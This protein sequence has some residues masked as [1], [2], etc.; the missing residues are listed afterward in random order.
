MK[1]LTMRRL[2]AI[3]MACLL[4]AVD[5][6]AHQAGADGGVRCGRK[7]SGGGSCSIEIRVPG[8]AGKSGKKPTGGSATR[9]AADPTTTAPPCVGIL[10]IPSDNQPGIPDCI[11][12]SGGICARYS[13]I[14]GLPTPTADKQ[15]EPGAPEPE[16]LARVAIERM[17]L[18][19]PDIGLW[20]EPLEDIPHGHSYVGWNNWM[21][22][23]NPTPTTWG[24]ITK[25]VTQAGH[26]ITATAAVTHVT[27]NMGN[28]DTKHCTKGTPHPTSHTHD[29]NS[30]TCG[31]VYHQRGDVT[32]TATAHWTITW[33]G[34]G[35]HGTITMDLSSHAHASIVE[36]HV[37][38]I[39]TGKHHHPTDT[40]TPSPNPTGTPT[41]LAPCPTNHNKHGC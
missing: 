11:E 34:L 32:I 30:P 22:I 41:E 8:S 14:P 15:P 9:P 13:N 17:D 35:Q 12:Y 25:T 19:A 20:P 38:N 3:V 7:D 21:W 6:P 18:H 2:I 29:E 16:T 27:W 33:T 5:L 10:C 1:H 23:N 39:P 4:I 40:T 24:P 31:Y 36:I 26:T 37:L 28:G